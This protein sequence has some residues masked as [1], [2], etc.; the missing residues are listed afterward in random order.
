MKELELEAKIENLDEVL[1]FVNVQ[2]EENSCS[3]KIQNQLL[4]CVEEIFANV[5]NYAYGSETGKIIIKT[6]IQEEPRAITVIFID[7]GKAYNPLEKPDPDITLK[8]ED[9]EIGGLGIFIVKRSVDYIS[10][11]YKDNKNILTIRKNF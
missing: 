7:S 1:D 8:A 9:R 10:Y 5:A 2:L 4:V 3:P 11:E 6:E